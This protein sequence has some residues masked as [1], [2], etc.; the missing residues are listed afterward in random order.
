MSAGDVD[1]MITTD[2]FVDGGASMQ[3]G[4]REHGYDF[5]LGKVNKPYP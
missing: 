5:P 3:E 2:F 4:T 1:S